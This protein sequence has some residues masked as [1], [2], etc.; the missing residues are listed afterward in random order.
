MVVPQNLCGAVGWFPMHFC[1]RIRNVVS[2]RENGTPRKP[3]W[4]AREVNETPPRVGANW[5]VWYYALYTGTWCQQSTSN[6]RGRYIYYNMVR[7]ALFLQRALYTVHCTIQCTQ[8]SRRLWSPPPFLVNAINRHTRLWNTSH[9]TETISSDYPW[10]KHY[11][12][13]M[14]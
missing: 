5:S 11:Q 6:T 8:E 7:S 14:Y 4:G 1:Q 3:G 9:F 13:S 2:I 12:T 10:Y